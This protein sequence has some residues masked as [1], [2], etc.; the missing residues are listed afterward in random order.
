MSDE[1]WRWWAATYAKEVRPIPPVMARA[2]TDRRRAFIGLTFVYVIAAL[3]ILSE[4]QNLRHAHTVM[5]VTSSLFTIVCVVALIVGLHVATW[6]IVGRTGSAPLQLLADLER[7]HAGRRRLIRL[8]PWLTG[9]VVCGS[10]GLEAASMIAAGR[11]DVSGAL[12]ALAVCGVTLG[13]VSWT[14]KRVGSVIDRELRQATEA[15]RLLTDGEDIEKD[16][17]TPG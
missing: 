11:F 14:V 12:G 15:R 1:E 5:A 17:P 16:Q 2:R 3:L 6:G 4:L 10:I 13:L 7:R 8:M 9:F